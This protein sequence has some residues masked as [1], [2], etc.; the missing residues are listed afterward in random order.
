MPRDK[1]QVT[2]GGG[3]QAVQ[4]GV[5]VTIESAEITQ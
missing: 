1:Q 3:W 4:S 5:K 2:A